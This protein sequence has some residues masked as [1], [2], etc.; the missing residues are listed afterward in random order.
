MWK[1]W[2]KCLGGSANWWPLPAARKGVSVGFFDDTDD[3]RSSREALDDAE[4][5]RHDD[6]ERALTEGGRQLTEAGREFAAKAAELGLV[7]KP[8]LQEPSRL[9][10][11]TG[12]YTGKGDHDAEVSWHSGRDLLCHDLWWEDPKIREGFGR[13]AVT[14]QGEVMAFV[15]LTYGSGYDSAI[16]V[17][18][19][20]ADAEG[21]GKWVRNTQFRTRMQDHE[22]A[23][24]SFVALALEAMGKYLRGLPT[25]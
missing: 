25:H 23:V 17:F 12:S 20:P 1:L 9:D 3:L 22:E 4:R 24:R 19:F 7:A 10:N 14:E 8:L 18:Y 11:A 2:A 16:Q 15:T 6:F 13:L 21:L 5:R